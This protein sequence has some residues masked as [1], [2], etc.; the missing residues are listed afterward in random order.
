MEELKLNNKGFT[1]IELLIAMLIVL[2]VMLG[3]LKGILEY[4]KFSIRAKMKD[5]ATE[6]AKQSTAYIESL[7]YVSDGSGVQSILYAN[8]SSWNNVICNSTSCSFFESETDFYNIG[9]PTGTNPIDG[10]SSKLRLY[11][12]S[13]NVNAQCSCSGSNCPSTLPVC[14]YEGF[15]GKKI[16]LAVNIAR[17]IDDYGRETGKAASVMVWYFEPFTNTLKQMTSVVIKEKR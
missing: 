5:K 7:P 11:P 6:I 14:T 13:N 1:L 17:I 4:N 2:I 3:L 10:L 12:S 16:Y 15:S 8:N 9:S